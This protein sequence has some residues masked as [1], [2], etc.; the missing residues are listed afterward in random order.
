MKKTGALILLLLC[1]FAAAFASAES[2]PVARSAQL[3]VYTDGEGNLYLPGRDEP[4]NT[5]PA[6]DVV[7]IDAYRAL[8]TAEDEALDALD[9][10]MIDLE[11]FEE[12]LLVEGVYDACLV[13][14]DTVYYVQELARDQVT[15]LALDGMTTRTAYTTGEPIERL[16]L[17]AEGLVV[18]LVDDA[19]AM[20]YVPETDR[21]VPY[22]GALPRSSQLADGYELYLTDAGELYL[23]NDFNFNA[24]FIDSDVTAYARM[25][26][27]VYYL[28]RT[29]VALRLK[30]YDPATQTWRIVLTPGVRVESQLTA[31]DHTLF[32]L[33]AEGSVCTVD[34]RAGT[35]SILSRFEDFGEYDL[36]EGYSVSGLRV[37]A[38]SGQLN[39]YAV[40]EEIETKP[41]FSFITFDEEPRAKAPQLRLIEIYP[42]DGEQ[43]AWDLLKP[44]PQYTPLARGSRGDAV[45]AIQQPLNALGY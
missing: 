27:V 18:Q 15:Q 4:V 40:L 14:E 38:M 19:G 45:R 37:E 20:L 21:F 44:A 35:M 30:A 3:A 8:F 24:D 32:M 17:S 25:D 2:G 6:V 22:A 43:T 5:T 7:A 33:T 42:L 41:D 12:T 16:Y 1:L 9:L 36:P 28:S 11:R 23:K 10:Y 31:S 26:G 39:V 29:G 34:T 13:D